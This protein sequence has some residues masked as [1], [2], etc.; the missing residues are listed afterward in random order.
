MYLLIRLLPLLKLLLLIIIMIITVC[1]VLCIIMYILKK[2]F[3]FLLFSA[4]GYYIAV[5]Y[6]LLVVIQ[7]YTSGFVQ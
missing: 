5:M 1:V 4:W 7:L 6:H 3:H 2:C